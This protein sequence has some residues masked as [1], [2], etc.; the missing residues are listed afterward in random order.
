MPGLI[1]AHTHP[2]IVD[3]DVFGLAEWPPAYVA[4]RAGRVAGRDARAG[5]HHDPRRRGR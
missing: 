2:A 3:H 4:A 1:D 5:F